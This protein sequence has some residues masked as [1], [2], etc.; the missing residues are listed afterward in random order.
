MSLYDRIRPVLFR[1]DA[2]RAHHLGVLA[3]RTAQR[4][5]PFLVRRMFAWES[6]R[7]RSVVFDREFP[8]PVG[9]AA[10]FDK[11]G[12]LVPF[13][14]LAGC[15]HVEIGSVSARP[16]R[17]NP[18]PR[19]FRLPDDEALINRMG[20][21]NQGAAR[22]AR[23]IARLAAAPAPLGINLVKTHDPAIA[24]EEAIR[25]FVDSFR[26]L[27]P[28]ADYVVLNL[29]CPNTTEGK[30]FEDPNALDD[31]LGAVFAAR[32]ELALRVPV[33]AKLSPP[34][35]DRVVFDSETEEIVSVAR[36]HGIAGFVASNT[37]ADREGLVT[38]PD[39]LQRIGR[40]GMSGAPL[41]GRSTHLVRYLYRL[42]GGSVPIIGVGGVA[43]AEH[44]Y[45]KIRAGA[46]LVQLYTG[47]VYHGPGLVRSI[48]TG[49]DRLLE[50]DGFERV[51]DAVG[52][53]A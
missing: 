53:D 46:R 9:L 8:N 22:V 43:S 27:A 39:A 28:L 20:L 49:L 2:E 31:L 38:D 45:R 32:S 26:L 16:A 40:G 29:S 3:G 15:G 35:S 11:N 42:T 44:A 36:S 18:R 52:A 47:L 12:V 21:N 19:A 48:K 23:R 25:D 10:G 1:L 24:G 5:A 51:E 33:L 4:L 34:V 41:E 50:A 17:G 14:R 30:T 37:A 13:W 7:L 6:D